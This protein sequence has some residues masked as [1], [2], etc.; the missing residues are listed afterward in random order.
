MRMPASHKSWTVEMLDTLPDDGSRYEVVDGELLV[1]PAQWMLHQR[2]LMELFLLLRPFVDRLGG[3]ELF[4]AP[5]A[6]RFS[7]VREVQPDLFV[8]PRVPGRPVNRFEDVGELAL[9]VEIFSPST[10][11]ADRY[12]KR[13]LF[14]SERVPQYWIVDP[15]SRL[16]ERWRP[17][18]EE[19]EVFVDSLSW[20]PRA[21]NAELV[22][23][24][25]RYFRTVHEE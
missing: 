25:E 12:T 13:R 4:V 21:G 7:H 22:I 14:Q 23:D 19:P 24:L 2:A 20:Q 3:L 16:V 18:D 17:D 8:I 5:T 9:A 15:A 11:R 10:A 1:S 6:V